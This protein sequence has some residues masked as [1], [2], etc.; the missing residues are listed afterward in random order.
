[1]LKCERL[2]EAAIHTSLLIRSD[3]EHTIARC[4]A[5]QERNTSVDIHIS[6]YL[7]TVCE[8]LHADMPDRQVAIGLS[9]ISKRPNRRTVQLEMNNVGYFSARDTAR[10]VDNNRGPTERELKRYD[11]V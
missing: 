2:I 4:T 3:V 5:K 10:C 9:P 6:R 8:L 1:M 11:T 7:W